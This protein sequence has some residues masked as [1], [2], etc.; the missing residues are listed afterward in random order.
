MFLKASMFKTTTCKWDK[1]NIQ[2]FK[3]SPCLHYGYIP[4][5]FIFILQLYIHI[6]SVNISKNKIILIINSSWV[7]FLLSFLILKHFYLHLKS[8]TSWN[9][10]K[11]QQ[12]LIPRLQTQF[13]LDQEYKYL[14]VL[15]CPFCQSDRLE[16]LWRGNS[17]LRNCLHQIGSWA[18][19]WSIFLINDVGG[20]SPCW[21]VPPL[22]KWF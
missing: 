4:S 3:I 19:V 12:R 8:R 5:T 20:H 10:I 18:R 15:C 6:Q 21:V 11:Q 9:I 13:I 17:Q 16:S 2:L 7:T 1:E 22:G 14:Q